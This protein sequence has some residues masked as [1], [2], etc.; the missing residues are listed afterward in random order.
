VFSIIDLAKRA[1]QITK[2][3]FERG[4]GRTNEATGLITFP[5]VQLKTMLFFHKNRSFGPGKTWTSS[6]K[7]LPTPL[8]LLGT[9]QPCR[10]AVVKQDKYSRAT[11]KRFVPV[12]S[13]YS[14]SQRKST[15]NAIKGYWRFRSGRCT[16]CRL[17]CECYEADRHPWHVLLG[18]TVKAKVAD[19]EVRLQSSN[20]I[21]SCLS[22][23]GACLNITREALIPSSKKIQ[24]VAKKKW[25]TPNAPKVPCA[26]R[27]RENFWGEGG[28][29]VDRISSS[30]V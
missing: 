4:I 2:Y 17:N 1:P 12:I 13:L 16:K 24:R 23:V 22:G 15:K 14:E 10:G 7:I 19:V 29:S 9:S 6:P 20:P 3:E 30:P 18:I 5:L 25:S 8:L 11:N 27:Q 28:G 21:K 26:A